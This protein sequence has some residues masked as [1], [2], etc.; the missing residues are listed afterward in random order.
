M[1]KSL[2]LLSF[3]LSGSF[4]LN[5][6]CTIQNSCTPT[7]GYCSTPASGSALPGG[8][9]MVAY[10]TTIQVSLASSFSGA[11]ITD[12]TV[13]SVSG[14]PTGLS[15]STNPTNGVINGGSD[16][17]ILVAG[18]PGTGTAGN[19][20]VTA[21]VT[22]NT[23]FGPIPG[24][25]TWSLSIAAPAGIASAPVT[26]STVLVTPNPATTQVNVA[27]DFHFQYAK[28]FDALGNL[29][30][31]QE[32]SGAAGTTIDI[33]KLNT[34]IYFLQVGDGKRSATRKFIKE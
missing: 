32:M 31:T 24:T 12:A 9:E 33:G 23:N 11:T 21:S 6:Q 8:T 20:V 3:F 4:A 14:L 1:K 2:L 30:I 17:C 15:Y 34:G 5:A 13:T 27:A 19:Y 16:G 10:S 18:T 25:L 22:V 26:N 7:S 28:V 29:V